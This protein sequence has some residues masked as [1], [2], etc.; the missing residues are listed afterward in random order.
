MAIALTVISAFILLAG[1]GDI[2]KDAIKQI[3]D[4]YY[5]IKQCNTLTVDS[6]D[7]HMSTEG[8]MIKVWLDRSGNI[9]ALNAVYYGETGKRVEEYYLNNNRVFFCL[10]Q[11]YKYNRPIYWDKDR[12]E[13]SGDSVFYDYTK[14]VILENRYYFDDSQKMIQW[15]NQNSKT[16]RDKNILSTKA[17]E[18]LTEYNFLVEEYKAR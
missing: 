4:E 7:T 6:V 14:S 5:A 3:R 16:I 17:N 13:A 12:A 11:D 1:Q 15:I 18:I 2:T 10:Y 9:K 8:G